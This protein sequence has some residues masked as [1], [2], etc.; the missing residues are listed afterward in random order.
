MSQY[1]KKQ[2]ILD[3]RK[4]QMESIAERESLRTRIKV[5]TR[6]EYFENKELVLCRIEDA[7]RKIE[8][9]SERINFYEKE[10][11]KASNPRK[12]KSK[13]VKKSKV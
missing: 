2:Q 3:L 4:M 8:S 12:Y 5:L 1:S 9:A 10:I 6:N 7:E 13:Y 11:L